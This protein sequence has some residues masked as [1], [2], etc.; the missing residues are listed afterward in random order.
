[1]FTGRAAAHPGG[2]S[3]AAMWNDPDRELATP[4]STRLLRDQAI[5]DG[6]LPSATRY[7]VVDGVRGWLYP[8]ASGLGDAF[9]LFVYFDGSGYQVKVAEPVMDARAD[10]HACHL[11]PD[12]RICLGEHA[13]GGMPTLAEAYSKSVVWCNGFSVYQRTGKF[14]F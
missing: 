7:R 6:N 1:M 5:V 12:A 9:V 13:G 11:F 4:A 10:S 14:P 8:V 3:R 2:R